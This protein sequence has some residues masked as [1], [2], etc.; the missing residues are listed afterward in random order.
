[1]TQLEPPVREKLVV[2]RAEISGQNVR[3]GVKVRSL[4]YEVK[5]LIIQT[6]N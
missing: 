6:K 3:D 5:E 1:M 4:A 2:L